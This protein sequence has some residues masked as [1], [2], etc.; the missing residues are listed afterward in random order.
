MKNNISP[1]IAAVVI[2]ILVVVIGGFCSLFWRQA[3]EPAPQGIAQ[4]RTSPVPMQQV[5]PRADG[6]TVNADGTGAQ[7]GQNQ[8][9]GAQGRTDVPQQ[10]FIP[11]AK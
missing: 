7:S 5:I 10:P 6:G 1:A 8:P 11:G 3:P 2:V 4:K 9:P